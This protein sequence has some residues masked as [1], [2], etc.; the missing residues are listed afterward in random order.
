MPKQTTRKA[1][2]QG[3]WR[4][5]WMDQWDQGYVDEEGEGYFEFDARGLGSFRFGGVHGQIDYRTTQRDGKTTVE[6]SWDGG[7]SADGTP[8][9]G[10]GWA[11]LDDEE[12]DGMIFIHVGDESA[13]KAKPTRPSSRRSKK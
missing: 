7:D 11:A 6:F 10:R 8:L 9:T 3:R 4:I 12:L 1:P 2:F 13:F 5:T